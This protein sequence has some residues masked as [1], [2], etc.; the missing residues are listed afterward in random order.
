ML[1][2]TLAVFTNVLLERPPLHLA[3]LTPSPE[4]P[5]HGVTLAGAGGSANLPAA[6]QPVE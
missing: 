2:H 1:M 4:K 5:A 6:A 3:W